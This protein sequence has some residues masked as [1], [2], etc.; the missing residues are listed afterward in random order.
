M[1]DANG[2]HTI[3]VDGGVLTIA[4]GNFYI[5]GQYEDGII[6][7][8]NHGAFLANQNGILSVVNTYSHV[9]VDISRCFYA[10]YASQVHIEK[11]ITLASNSYGIWAHRGSFV[12][13]G[14][15]LT[16]TLK[17]LFYATGS[18]IMYNNADM[19]AAYTTLVEINKGAIVSTGET[20]ATHILS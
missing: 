4:D 14:G 9:T 15:K 10:N 20:A 17:T 11:N 12:A 13:L 5:S 7:V 6:Y 18:I 2:R 1:P 8:T 16:A 19:T 3:L